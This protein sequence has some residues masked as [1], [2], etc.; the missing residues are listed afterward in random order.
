LTAGGELV[1]EYARNQVLRAK[2]TYNALGGAAQVTTAK[3]I[4][5]KRT[6]KRALTVA[7]TFVLALPL[8]W[9]AG[10]ALRGRPVL[11]GIA[12]VATVALGL[13]IAL[14]Q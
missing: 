6:F 5:R 9:A 8:G 11:A 12:L 7:M 14:S 1:S 4:M 10:L 2:A 3:V 13:V